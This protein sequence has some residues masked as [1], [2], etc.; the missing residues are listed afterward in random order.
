MN[1]IFI[2][3]T[4]AT[5]GLISHGATSPESIGN[6]AVHNHNDEIALM[7]FQYGA[8]NPVLKNNGR[9]SG[10][11]MSKP[12]VITKTIDKSSP[13]LYQALSTGETL[14]EMVLKAYRTA[15]N[16]K[17]EHYLTISLKDSRVVNKAANN[18]LETIYFTYKNMTI[19]HVAANTIAKIEWKQS[20]PVVVDKPLL[21]RIFDS[22]VDNF[23]ATNAGLYELGGG[24]INAGIAGANA[25]S[26]HLY[27]KGQRHIFFKEP[28]ASLLKIAS[29]S[30][31][32]SLGLRRTGFNFRSLGPIQGT[33]VRAIFPALEGA[34]YFEVGIAL[35]SVGQ[36]TAEEVYKDLY[37]TYLRE[38]GETE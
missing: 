19:E 5:Q 27:N 28:R 7:A 34:F 10:L 20:S 4:G 21:D 30:L 22:T 11:G 2:K 24:V 32:Q 35:G 14:T 23:I 13:L 33:L 8:S 6:C 3:I 1:N 9:S 36:A 38:Y 17:H 12:F 37:K 18:K 15:Y 26:N 31:F 29:L 16:G 25:L